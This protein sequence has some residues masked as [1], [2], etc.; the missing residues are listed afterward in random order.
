MAFLNHFNEAF[1]DNRSGNS[2]IL[3]DTLL[4]LA[5]TAKLKQKISLTDIPFAVT[6]AGLL[7][8]LGWN[9]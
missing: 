5:I 4:A 1:E 2:H 6:D 9:A 8:E 3:S 7:A